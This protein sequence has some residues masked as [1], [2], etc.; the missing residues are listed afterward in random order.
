MDE[1]R[2]RQLVEQF[3]LKHPEIVATWQQFES[4]IDNDLIYAEVQADALGQYD[5]AQSEIRDIM[6]DLDKAYAKQVAALTTL[7]CQH[8]E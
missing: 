4:Q 7:K 2:A 8:H 5:A 3:R 6:L 1:K